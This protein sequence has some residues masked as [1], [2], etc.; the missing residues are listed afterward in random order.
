MDIQ[1]NRNDLAFERGSFRVRGDIIDIYPAGGESAVR[2]E[3]FGD[4]VESIREINP[5][6]GEIIGSRDHIAIFPASHYVTSP[7]N[8]E[9]ALKTIDEELE[10][11]IRWFKDRGK[12]LEAQRIE[13]RTR[14]DLEML[15]E[16]GTCKGI[17]NYSRHLNGL[18]AGSRPYT[19][20]GLFSERLSHNDRRV[21]CHA[22]A[23]SGHVRGR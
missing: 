21:P 8:M 15:R 17:E 20:I 3:L 22:A 14:Y 4:E 1:Y 5:V 19:L 23:A 10:E 2:V 16:V 9:K 7:E 11:R 6:T 12:L 13:Q 18:K